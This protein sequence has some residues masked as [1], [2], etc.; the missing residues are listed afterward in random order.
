MNPT[1][2]SHNAPVNTRNARGTPSRPVAANVV[3]TA[4]ASTVIGADADTSITHNAGP[5]SELRA[6]PVRRRLTARPVPTRR[7]WA[8]S[9][10]G[11]A[12]IGSHGAAGAGPNRDR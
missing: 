11:S 6:K 9:L 2:N 1:V 7:R 4:P 3:T 8:G 5:R 10:S 12:V